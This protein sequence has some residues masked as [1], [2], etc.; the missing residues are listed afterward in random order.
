[1]TIDQTIRLLALVTL[2]EMMVFVGLSAPLVDFVNAA[3]DLRR[4][5]LAVFA[6]YLLVPVVT[7][8]LLAVFRAPP[9]VAVGFLILAVCPGGPYGPPYTAIAKGNVGS[10]AGL[11]V[12][13]AGLSAFL[14][15]V[16]LRGLVRLLPGN[17]PVSVDVA[18]MSVTLLLGQVAPLLGGLAVRRWRPRQADR[19]VEPARRGATFLNIAFLILVVAVQYRMLLQIRAMALFGMLVL[20]AASMAVGW[21]AG[22]AGA[23][24][25]RAM[26]LTTSV[27]NNGVGMVIATGAFPGTAAVTAAIVYGLVGFLGSLLLALWWGRRPPAESPVGVG[28][29]DF[30][31]L[32]S[33]PILLASNSRTGQD[34]ASP[35][36][37]PTAETASVSPGTGR[38]E[39]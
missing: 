17:Q 14:S 6:N 24:D 39:L 34:I 2:V 25:R 4:V 8:A 38:S 33:T 36:T 1:M 20:L 37:R 18:A 21:L 30:S 23:G 31:V 15:P 32:P 13:L 12:I 11:M 29:S 35:S 9:L 22:G 19:L 3:K 27:R 26:T 5:G 10:A 7:V 28:L 16:L